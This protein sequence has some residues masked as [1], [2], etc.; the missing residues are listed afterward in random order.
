M[1]VNIGGAQGDGADIIEFPE[2]DEWD[3]RERLRK[4]KE[5][6]GFYITG[7]PLDRY[8]RDLNNIGISTIDSLSELKD[9]S[10]VK[11]GGVISD[12]K[13]KRTKERKKMAIV[14]FEDRTGSVEI[15]VFPDT[16]ERLGHILKEDEPLV[17]SGIVDKGENSP[18][19]LANDISTIESFKD[20][21]AEALEIEIIEDDVGDE[22]IEKL[23]VSFREN[24]GNCHV[25]FKI[26]TRHSGTYL[27]MADERYRV[28]PTKDL[29]NTVGQLVKKEPVIYLKGMNFNGMNLL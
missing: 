3:E 27:V 12:L 18:K 10:E 28:S 16:F 21:T 19:I 7:H 8:E 1:F 2:M 13:I 25:Y 6:L 23:K 11:V 9:R 14:N 5:A 29:I 15:L 26:K 24:P 4:E 22:L 17:V 20:R